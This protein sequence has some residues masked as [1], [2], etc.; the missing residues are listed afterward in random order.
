MK[1]LK[2]GTKD[3]F[4]K[5]YNNSEE[6]WGFSFRVAQ[7][8]RYNAYLQTLKQ[9]SDNDKYSSVLDIGCS[10]GQF[11]AMLQ[12]I[13]SNISA[14][15]ISEMAIQRAKEKYD[16]CKK[17]RFEVGSLPSLK[18]GNEQFDL[19]LALEVLYYLE[20]EERI[21]A[22]KEIKRVMKKDGFLLISVNIGKVPYFKI[23][24]FYNLINDFF[25][26]RT[27]EYCYTRIYSFFERKLLR[28]ERTKLQKI[29][30]YLLS[31]ER[32]V[33]IGQ[34]LTK[35][36]FGRKGITIMYIM[37]QKSESQEEEYAT[38]RQNL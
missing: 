29:I 21:K 27:V 26:I 1:K 3:Y 28:L 35:L 13:A 7:Q 11:T 25:Q 31:L 23:D 15:D 14:I 12:G 38:K 20:K 8:Y 37:A 16:D 5:L 6:P 2:F 22:L 30:R 24:E 18:Y 34:R 10:Q 17:I 4:D 19:V 33:N 32:L 9:F 36:I